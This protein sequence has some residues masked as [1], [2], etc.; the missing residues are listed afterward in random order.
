M[1]KSTLFAA[2]RIVALFCCLI[3]I[4]SILC[5]PTAAEELSDLPLDMADTIYLYNI[6]NK[7]PIV[8]KNCD[9]LIY[10]AST[11]KMM[12]GLVAIEHLAARLDEKITITPDMLTGVVGQYCGWLLAGDTPTVRD[13]LYHAI[14]GGYND[15]IAIITRVVAG[16][17]SSFVALMNS[18]AKALGMSKTYYTNATGV[19]D[20]LMVTTAKDVATL[21]LAAY[22]TPLFLE[23]SS[24]A[25]YYSEGLKTQRDFPNRNCLMSKLRSTLYYNPLCRGLNAGA[26]AQGGE[27]VVTVAEDGGISYLCIVMGGKTDENGRVY[28]YTIAN[29]LIGWVYRTYGYVT[30]LSTSNII[31]EIPVNMASDMEAVTVVPETDLSFFLPLGTEIG[32]DVTFDHTLTVD[33]L[34]APVSEGTPVG[35]IS[36]MQGDKVLATVNL[37]TKLSV[38]QSKL[39][40]AFERIKAISQSRVFIASVISAVVITTIYIIGKSAIRG[41]KGK[42]R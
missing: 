23:I 28:S 12:M 42:F 6:E 41:S 29:R 16:S 24:T 38:S 37:V 31:C 18:K 19:H 36:V 27:C 25:E 15:A 33:S 7:V 32:K 34:T 26:T 1:K 30:V 40:Y 13:L 3:F 10:P 21:A 22:R 14:C 2:K 17:E 9:E 35:F 20:G 8:E 11:V 5:L 39:L 4:F